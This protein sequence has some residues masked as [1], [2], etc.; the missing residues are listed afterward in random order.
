M[1]L[2]ERTPATIRENFDVLEHLHCHEQFSVVGFLKCSS[3]WVLFPF[4]ENSLLLMHNRTVKISHK[5]YDL[6]VRIVEKNSPS[7]FKVSKNKMEI[8]T[9]TSA[10]RCWMLQS[11]ENCYENRMGIGK[12]LK[13]CVEPILCNWRIF[14]GKIFRNHIKYLG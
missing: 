5:I 10:G 14:N 3:I 2:F 9:E 4:R 6:L 7:G 12:H 13:S 1:L 8:F 11:R